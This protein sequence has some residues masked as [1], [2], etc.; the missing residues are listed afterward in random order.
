MQSWCHG[1]WRGSSLTPYKEKG[2]FI[3]KGTEAISRR[4]EI[5]VLSHR[6][7]KRAYLVD[8]AGEK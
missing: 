3:W 8:I 4:Q 6:R 7:S 5:E 2:S 1:A